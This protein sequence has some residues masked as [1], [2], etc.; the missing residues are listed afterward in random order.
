LTSANDAYSRLDQVLTFLETR[1]LTNQSLPYWW[2]QSFDG[3]YSD[4]MSSAIQYN[5]GNVAD[6]G[7]LLI[8]LKNAELYNSSLTPRIN[9][10]VNVI[11]NYT[12]E[13]STISTLSN[14][15]NI[16]DYYV[17][18]GFAYF[19]PQFSSVATKILNNIITAQNV[20]T[21]GVSLPAAKLTWTPLFLSIVDLIQPDQRLFSLTRQVYLAHE[22]YYN[23]T[24]Q[25]RAFNEGTVNSGNFVWEWVVLPNGTTWAVLGENGLKYNFSDAPV[26]Y[27]DT[28]FGFLALYNTTYARNL[29]I[30]LEN[31]LRYNV[32]EPSRM[33]YYDGV[34]ENGTLLTSITNNENG[35]I[36][37]AARYSINANP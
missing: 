8:A 18:S 1:P 19:W 2:Y 29:C 37:S 34:Q 17:A 22:A 12:L 10:V 7:N 33:G 32:L 20:N 23:T 13:F 31:A 5:N 26:I 27:C 11:T 4:S 21:Y 25:Y 35:M 36:L 24:G 16:Y 30:Y 6:A 9:Q 28:A 3:N 15:V 14:S